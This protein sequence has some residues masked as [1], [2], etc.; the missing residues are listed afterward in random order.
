METAID[1]VYVLLQVVA[2]WIGSAIPV[3]FTPFMV[4][5]F[6]W[7]VAIFVGLTTWMYVR[8][9]KI[10]TPKDGSVYMSLLAAYM[11]FLGFASTIMMLASVIHLSG[12][13]LA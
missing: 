7:P 2:D 11:L 1:K 5:N 13:Q 9:G 8:G 12:A 3:P 4:S 10:Y 6:V